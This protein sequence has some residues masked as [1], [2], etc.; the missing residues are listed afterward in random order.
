LDHIAFTYK[1]LTQLAQLY[2]SLRD[3]QNG[4]LKPIWSINYGLTTSLY[5]R[6]P[7]GNKIGIQVDNFDTMEL[8]L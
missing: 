2:V 7:Q 5:Y 6:D 1:S 8:S 4:P 3:R